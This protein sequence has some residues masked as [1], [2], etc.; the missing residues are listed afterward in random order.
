[1]ATQDL[2]M[3]ESRGQIGFAVGIRLDRD[4]LEVRHLEEGSSEFNEPLDDG[5][6]TCTTGPGREDLREPKERRVSSKHGGKREKKEECTHDFRLDPSNDQFEPSHEHAD[7]AWSPLLVNLP[8]RL[9]LPQVFPPVELRQRIREPR[10]GLAGEFFE[11]DCVE[12][13]G[14]DHRE[15]RG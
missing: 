5:Q 10:R 13:L 3:K 6:K 12:Q 8:P 11:A 14:V 2:V 7:V 9:F 1:M 4:L 15:L